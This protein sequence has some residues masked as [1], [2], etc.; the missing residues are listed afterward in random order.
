M[1]VRLNANT[2]LA[3]KCIGDLCLAI[4]NFDGVHLGHQ[5]L[6][7]QVKRSSYTPAVMMFDPHPRAFFGQDIPTITPLKDKIAHLYNCG[8]QCILVLEFDEQMAHISAQD[9]I[10][11]L[12]RLGVHQVV[13]G[14]DFRFGRNRIG[15]IEMLKQQFALQE[16]PDITQGPSRI[17][18][19]LVRHHLAQ[20]ALD[21][22]ERLL[23]RP[24]HITG[25]VVHGK[26]LGRQLGFATANID[27]NHTLPIGGIFAVNVYGIQTDSGLQGTQY[28]SRFGVANIGIRPSI[29]GQTSTLE[30][31][32]P[33]FC[34][35]LY[36]QVLCI[37]PIHFLHKERHY[38]NLNALQEGIAKDVA[39]ALAYRVRALAQRPMH[40]PRLASTVLDKAHFKADPT[41]FI[42]REHL[43]FDPQGIG[44]HLWLYFKKTHLSTHALACYLANWAGCQV[45]DVG[46]SGKKDTDAVTYQWFSVPWAPDKRLDVVD[47]ITKHLVGGQGIELIQ[48]TRHPKKLKTGTHTHNQF[49]LTLT[50]V[51]RGDLKLPRRVAVPNYFGAQRFGKHHDNIARAKSVLKHRRHTKRGLYLSALRAGLFNAHLA[52]RI[53]SKTMHILPGDVVNLT[54]TGSHFIA[55]SDE[56]ESLN[57][58]A[59][60][61]EVAPSGVLWGQGGLTPEGMAKQLMEDAL[62]PCTPWMQMLDKTGMARSWRPLLLWVDV[63]WKPLT[64]GDLVLDFCLPKGSYATAVLYALVAHLEEGAAP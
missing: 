50:C 58:R 9:F 2:F 52:R 21:K 16:S 31:H 61:G 59:A 30:V 47:C 6:L 42:M 45:V 25:K 62:A 24:Y 11:G 40:L 63:Q 36:G 22:A 15:N 1:I 28:G 4:G 14:T 17:S 27:H 32:L 51:T 56:V 8:M 60:L 33:G 57:A 7:Q 39:D 34:G 55:V 49:T 10:L 18:S 37:E 43:G 46:T 41:H 64:N 20:G 35:N 54:G 26:K 38:P 23:G 13:V 29:G 12:K 19:T 3:G 48:S 44:G 53:E 5:A